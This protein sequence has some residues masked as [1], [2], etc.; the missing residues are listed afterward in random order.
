MTV[1][2]LGGMASDTDPPASRSRMLL[3]SLPAAAIA[4]VGLSVIW[5]A[6]L[7]L[8]L[9]VADMADPSARLGFAVKCGCIAVLLAFLTGLE[10]ISHERLVTDAFDPLAGVETRRLR[11]NARYVQNTAEQ[12]LVFLPGLLGLA[13]YSTTGEAMRA[14]EAATVAWIAFRFVFWIG[15]HR[16]AA[17]RVPGLI[18]AAQSMLILLYVSTRFG[19]ETAGLIGAALPGSIFGVVEVVIIRNLWLTRQHPA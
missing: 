3:D 14:V 2:S 10:A 18:G 19:W 9:P 1:K 7:T 12:L 13:L 15:Y 4:L 17:G 8:A 16:S 11:V 6:V 5:G